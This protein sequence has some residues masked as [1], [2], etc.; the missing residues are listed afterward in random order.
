MNANVVFPDRDF[1]CICRS[2]HFSACWA[3][4]WTLNITYAF[5]PLVH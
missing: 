1:V 3:T 2:E 4:I 5:L